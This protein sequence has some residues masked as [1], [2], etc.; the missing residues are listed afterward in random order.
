M[1]KGKRRGKYGEF[2]GLLCL[3]CVTFCLVKEL[4]KIAITSR[5]DLVLVKAD[6]SRDVTK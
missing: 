4:S 1:P 5:R 3:R 6:I 2:R